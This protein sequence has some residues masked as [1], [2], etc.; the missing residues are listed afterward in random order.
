MMTRTLPWVATVALLIGAW[1]VQLLTP[2]DDLVAE[3]FLVAASVGSEAVG[4]EIVVTVLDVRAA[5]SVTNSS[6][7]SAEGTW[8]LVDLNAETV[9]AD[10]VLRGATLMI[11][12]IEFRASERMDSMF[13]TRLVPGIPRTG[14]IAF[15]LPDA[16]LTGTG[17]LHLSLRDDTRLDSVIELTIPLDELTISAEES[18]HVTEW[19][20]S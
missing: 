8:L 6:G 12:G 7:W 18:V 10:Q 14:T 5:G 15:E 19:A 2:S 16:S 13:S 9:T 17:I 1:F 20:T 3:P 4:R 11:D